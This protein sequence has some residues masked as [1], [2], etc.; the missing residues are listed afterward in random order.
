MAQAN[1]WM[2]SGPNDEL[3]YIIVGLGNNG[4]ESGCYN[5][6]CGFIQIDSEIAPGHLFTHISKFDGRT[7][8][9]KIKIFQDKATSNWLLS[10]L[11]E[12]IVVGYFPPKYFP[13]L[14]SGAQTV[15][16][17]GAAYIGNDGNSPP[18]GSGY[19]PDGIYNHAAYFRKLTYFDNQW[20]LR[21]P[22]T[23]TRLFHHS[24][25]GHCYGFKNGTAQGQFWGSNFFF[26]GPGGQ[27][28][29]KN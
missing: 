15:A 8:D 27:K 3:N 16:W 10:V 6:Q 20:V 28:C 22:S 29:G 5:L 13:Y 24:E 19:L 1:I 17:G 7:V 18:M 25:K 21:E 2:Q 4:G 26:G 12:E 9:V 23:G 11:D 14:K